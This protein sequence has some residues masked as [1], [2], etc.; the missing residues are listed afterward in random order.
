MHRWM[1]GML[2]GTA[3]AMT[4]A[5]SASA[6]PIDLPAK[7][8]TSGFSI[9]LNLNGSAVRSPEDF[10]SEGGG[11]GIRLSYGLNQ[12]VAL[13]L[14]VDGAALGTS[15]LTYASAY[16]VGHADLGVRVSLADSNTA[17]V[18]YVEGAYS[19]RAI[20]QEIAGQDLELTGNAATFGG[21]IQHFFNRRIALDAGLL[22]SYGK[23]TDAKV[24]GE[25]FS[26]SGGDSTWSS[27][28]NLGLRMHFR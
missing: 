21:G 23:F 10:K 14:G 26:D 4:M 5:G 16:S 9:G 20:Y 18:P 11:L 27:R 3:L 2:S 22:F 13:Y 24:N 28:F 12:T 6:Q 1:S 7:S 8:N 25:T 17:T 19:G 15:N